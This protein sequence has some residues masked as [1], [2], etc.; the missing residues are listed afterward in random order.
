MKRYSVTILSAFLAF[1]LFACP[2]LAARESAPAAIIPYCVFSSYEELD[3][4]L[5]SEEPGAGLW[6][7]ASCHTMAVSY[8]HLTLPTKA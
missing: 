1:E 6:D 2:A 3:S 4:V 8:T 5:A 7:K